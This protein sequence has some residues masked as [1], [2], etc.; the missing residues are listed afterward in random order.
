MTAPGPPRSASRTASAVQGTMSTAATAVYWETLARRAVDVRLLT[1]PSTMMTWSSRN[2][3]S[4]GASSTSKSNRSPPP[5]ALADPPV[6]PPLGLRR[7]G[8]G[9]CPVTQS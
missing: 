9:L 5:P 8:A 4:I 2:D 1:K 3:R 6:S 7:A